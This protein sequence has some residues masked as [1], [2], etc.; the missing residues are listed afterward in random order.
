M[1]DSGVIAGVSVGHTRASVEEIET[2]QKADAATLVSDLLAH[3]GVDEAFA[4]GTT[5]RAS[6]T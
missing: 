3:E 5:R 2:A 4:I 1:T 6:A